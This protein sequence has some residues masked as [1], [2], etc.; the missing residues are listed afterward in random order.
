MGKPVS[1]SDEYAETPVL[2]CKT[3]PRAPHGFLRN[4]SHDACRY[5][6]ECEHW[7]P[8]AASPTGGEG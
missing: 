5:V 4:E 6:C 8:R 1:Q 7:G 3:D 2:P